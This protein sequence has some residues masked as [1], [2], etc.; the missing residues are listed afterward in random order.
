MMRYKWLGEKGL[1]TISHQVNACWTTMRCLHTL[2]KKSKVKKSDNTRS[3]QGFGMIGTFVDPPKLYKMIQLFLKAVWPFIKYTF[4]LCPKMSLLIYSRKV[5]TCPEKD[6][7]MNIHNVSYDSQN[8][9]ATQ[10]SI[11][12]RLDEQIGVKSYNRIRFSSK[13]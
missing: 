2:T 13:K 7:S 9:E 10:M 4:I 11:N 12:R 3:W 5:K 6:L 8:L 1:Q